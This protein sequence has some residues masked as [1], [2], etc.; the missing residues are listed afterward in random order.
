LAITAG[1]EMRKMLRE[2]G[3]QGARQ[4][5]HLL[6]L[7]DAFRVD[8]RKDLPRVKPR[9]STRDE[10]GVQLCKIHRSQI[11]PAVCR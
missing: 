2:I 10:R 3:A 5:R 8:P 9:M 11:G 1:V 7:V 4:I 6:E